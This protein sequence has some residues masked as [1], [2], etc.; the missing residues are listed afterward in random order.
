MKKTFRIIS[1]LLVLCL[2]GGIFTG[3][4]DANF[5]RAQYK[6]LST[7]CVDSGVMAENSQ[8]ILEWDNEYKCVIAKS[9]QTGKAWCTTPYDLYIEGETSAAISSPIEI[10]VIN[11]TTKVIDFDRAYTSCI[12]TGNMSAEKIDNGIKVTYY[13]D[14]YAVSVPICYI[15]REDSIAITFDTTKVTEGDTY[16]LLRVSVAPFMCSA[17]NNVEGNYIFVPSGTGALMKAVSYDGSKVT[18]SSE[19]YGIDGSRLYEE[20]P[21]DNEKIK[22]PVFGAKNG[23][24]ALMGIIEQGAE[25]AVINAASRDKKSGY[26]NVYPTIYTR[27][28]D[29]YAEKYAHN[30]SFSWRNSEIMSDQNVVIGYYFLEGEKASYVGMAERYRQYLI[31]K[32]GLKKSSQKENAYA[33]SVLGNIMNKKLAFGFPYSKLESLTTFSQTE[34]IITELA[35]STGLYPTVQMTG[36][37][38]TGIDVGEI[39]DGYKFASV[40]GS[41]K[42][43]KKIEELAKKG[44]F[45]LSV[46]FDLLNFNKSGSGVNTYSNV[47]KSA[48]KFK[49]KQSYSD[50]AVR[51]FDDSYKSYYLVN[52]S[53]VSGLV[54]K[55]IKKAEK[56]GITGIS[57]ST[58]GQIAYSDY[59]DIKYATR[60]Q[61]ETDV[62]EYLKRIKDAGYKVVTDDAN[63]YAATASDSVLNLKIEPY[64]MDGI[65]QYVPFYQIVFKGYVPL[66]SEPLNLTTNYKESVLYALASGTGLGYTVIENY[67]IDYATTPHKNLY[68]SLYRDLKDEITTSVSEYKSYYDAIEGAVIVNYRILDT[69]VTETVFDNG[70]VAYTNGSDTAKDSPVGQL[71][72][73]GFKYIK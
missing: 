55:L 10:S 37:G 40:S 38:Q 49:V 50:V 51:W 22:M 3:C 36:F 58:L 71:S 72:A 39:A 46:D 25:M 60:L 66:Y 4:G 6:L 24:S 26:A 42:D 19:V 57:T 61:T 1:F 7:E 67:N 16:K 41:V 18:Y 65:D 11:S 73:Y 70:V 27:G 8:F 20:L 28:Y 29:I 15:I 68:N 43:Y 35:S 30:A 47:A 64:N 9:K 62:A 33:V 13:F 52:R 56:L 5:N 23:D 32:K 54:D 63:V 2:V 44:N 59:S 12:K 31:E 48:S 53:K 45:L 21:I 34:K 69:G 17:E 14:T